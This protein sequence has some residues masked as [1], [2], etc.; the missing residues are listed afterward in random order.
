MKI[1]SINN[2]P[3]KF[4]NNHSTFSRP[5][6]GYY[7]VR[8]RL[9]IRNVSESL[10]WRIRQRSR[11]GSR[12]SEAVRRRTALFKFQQKPAAADSLRQVNFCSKNLNKVLC[13]DIWQ[14]DVLK[15]EVAKKLNLVADIFQQ[16]LALPFERKDLV[17]VGSMASHNYGKFSDIDLH[18]VT[19]FSKYN[20]DERLLADYFKSKRDMF[21]YTNSF[22]MY[23][24][25]V[26]VSV[27]D[28]ARKARSQGRYS[29]MSGQWLKKPLYD[30]NFVIPDV[31]NSERYLNLKKSLDECL[32]NNDF[33]KITPLF[34]EIYKLREAGLSTGG[35][36][37]QEN[38]IFRRLRNEG[39]LKKLIDLSYNALNNLISLN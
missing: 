34:Q 6:N 4:Y 11:Y 24:H 10:E 8:E 31:S 28:V 1:N 29:I 14:N 36:L 9:A 32:A 22:M 12:F 19:D 7:Y 3:Y 5:E 2:Y 26:E 30:E 25:P 18:L 37:S 38:L 20:T 17:L 35:E 13:P 23:G 33:K 16:T 15:P 39:Y 27:E 21:N